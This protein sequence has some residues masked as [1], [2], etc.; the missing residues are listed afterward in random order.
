MLRSVKTTWLRL[1][2][3]LFTLLVCEFA[4][5]Q[6]F[7]SLVMPGK[8]IEGHAK[9][10]SECK[11]CH[12]PFKKTE[13]SSLCLDCHKDVATDIKAKKGF[14]GKTP[15]ARGKECKTCHTD[16]K[17]RAMKIATF[18]QSTFKHQFT[19]YPLNGAHT[20]VECKSCHKASTKF[21]DA[22]SGCNDCHKKDDVH[23]ASLGAACGDCHTEKTWKDAKFDHDRTRFALSGKHITATCKSCHADTNYKETPRA[24]IACHKKEDAHKGRYGDKCDSCHDAKDWKQSN[25]SHA[26]QGHWALLGKH[27]AAKCEACHRA[28]LYAEKL[29]NK[30]V[31]CHRNDDVHKGSLGEKCESC[32]NERNWKTTKFDHNRDTKFSLYNKHKDAKCESCHKNGVQEKLPTACLSCHLKEDTH[33]GNFG[34]K[35][36]SCHN[37]AAWKPSTFDHTK[38]TRYPLKFEHAV[39][40][41]EACHIGKLYEKEGAKLPGMTCLACHQKDDVHKGQEGKLCESCHDEKTWKKAKFDHNKSVFPLLGAHHAVKCGACHRTQQYKDAPS[42]CIGCHEKEDT[43]KKTLGSQ[44]DSCHNV[45]SWK[46]WDFDHATQTKYLLEGAHTNV[47]C[48]ACHRAEAPKSNA[49][50]A[51]FGGA[52]QAMG[53]IAPTPLTCFGCH[54]ADDKHEGSFG[55]QCDRCHVVSSWKT[56][57]RVAIRGVGEDSGR[58]RN[59]LDVERK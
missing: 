59:S 35:C 27:A 37:D 21:R 16:H 1:L 45:R 11:N 5:A 2:V 46:T 34:K 18:D 47:K 29:M 41:C 56:I 32:H 39:I 52:R 25:F 14:H 7:D 44:C 53:K 42:T 10:E 40:K 15:D 22:P 48:I 33:K 12:L 43:H 20:K 9:I 28:P 51:K 50:A 26:K 6:V 3:A 55:Q 54:T 8:V 4:V 38:S 49:S 13:Q 30:C 23:K 17:G 24:C 58:G 19:D 36:E 57:K 31:S